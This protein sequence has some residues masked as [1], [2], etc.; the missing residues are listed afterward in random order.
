MEGS[1]RPK[2][3]RVDAQRNRVRVLE[4]AAAVF[5]EQGLSASVRDVAARA[6]VGLGTVAR[7]FPTKELLLDAIVLRAVQEEVDHGNA[8]A[9]EYE[10]GRAF[11]TFLSYLVDRGNA[12]RGLADALTGAGFDVE[13]AAS[14]AD[15]DVIQVLQ[16]LLD[17]AQATGDVRPDVDA[18]D[19]KALVVGCLA[20]ERRAPDP[21]ARTRMLAVLRRGLHVA[22]P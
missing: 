4:A 21:A 15:L 9:A 13:K 5:A 6:G 12:N 14:R 3:L 19:V 22:G 11:F 7:H 1:A 18:A 10:P 16:R 17:G 20:R 8:L 2:P